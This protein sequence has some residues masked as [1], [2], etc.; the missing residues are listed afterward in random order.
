MWRTIFDAAMRPVVIVLVQVA[1]D[2]FSRLAETAIFRRPHFLF[3]HNPMLDVTKVQHFLIESR[4]FRPGTEMHQHAKPVYFFGNF[5]L[6]PSERL[7]LRD[8]QV[9]SL[10]PKVFEALVLL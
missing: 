6:D 3:L 8:K 5:R 7:L 1:A 9:I 4:E 2:V 10:T